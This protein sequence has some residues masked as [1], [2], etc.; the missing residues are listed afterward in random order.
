MGPYPLPAY[1][2]EA[3][4]RYISEQDEL[5]NHRHSLRDNYELVE[6]N[7]EMLKVFKTHFTPP[8]K[9]EKVWIL[10]FEACLPKINPQN[11][12]VQSLP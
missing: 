4:I 5:Q 2:H 10:I 8:Q 9:T 11:E 12:D 1:M 7:S 6:Q 3:R